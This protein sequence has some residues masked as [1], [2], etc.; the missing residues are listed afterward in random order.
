M[1]PLKKDEYIRFP[2]FLNISSITSLS[3]LAHSISLKLSAWLLKK[4]L[5]GKNKD[6]L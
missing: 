4:A 6:V 2:L 5:S 3:V 1:T